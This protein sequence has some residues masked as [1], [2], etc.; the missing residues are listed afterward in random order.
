[1]SNIYVY[2]LGQRPVFE[3]LTSR[4][5]AKL[6]CVC[7]T[8]NERIN[9][10]AYEP[11]TAQKA[12]RKAFMRQKLYRALCAS[13]YNKK[14]VNLEHLQVLS[15]FDTVGTQHIERFSICTN[16]SIIKCAPRKKFIEYNK[17][18]FSDYSCSID[19]LFSFIKD[20][21]VFTMI[22]VSNPVL[23]YGYFSFIRNIDFMKYVSV[24]ILGGTKRELVFMAGPLE[25]FRA[26]LDDRTVFARALLNIPLIA[27]FKQ[28]VMCSVENCVQSKYVLCGT[29]LETHPYRKRLTQALLR[30]D[31]HRFVVEEFDSCGKKIREMVYLRDIAISYGMLGLTRV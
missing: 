16:T 20:Y 31:N 12:L 19:E 13:I 26:K 23:N 21:A 25:I 24:Q 10:H 3:C 9:F 5:R 7:K 11:H 1:M 8:L 27:T 6:H 2:I 29:V 17:I 18:K 30:V 28:D 22:H 4:V 15:E 14:C